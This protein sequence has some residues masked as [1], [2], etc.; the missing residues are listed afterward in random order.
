[1]SKNVQVIAWVAFIAI[2][3]GVIFYSLSG[4][5]NGSSSDTGTVSGTQ[6][7]RSVQMLKYSDYSCPACKAY[8]PFQEQLK[9]DFGDQLT[10]EYRHF[11]LGGF[12]YSELA[13]RAVEA[14]AEQGR[15]KEMHD[16]IFDEQERWTQ[17]GAEE[18]FLTFAMEIGLDIEQF[19][20]DLHADRIRERVQSQRA[21]GERRMV[22]STPTFFINGQRIQQNPQS[23]EQFRSIVEMYMYR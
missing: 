14:A 7:A 12:Q 1:M 5:N 15:K 16:R 23:Y 10:I 11:P 17:G 8:I 9:R 18:F 22:Q 6:E 19:E 3:G 21:E 20:A 13:A 2:V 4:D